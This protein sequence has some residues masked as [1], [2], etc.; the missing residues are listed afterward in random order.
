MYDALSAFD[1]KDLEH[2]LTSINQQLTQLPQTHAALWDLFKTL[3]NKKDEEAY[4]RLLADEAIV[5]KTHGVDNGWV[6]PA[7]GDNLT[8]CACIS[9]PRRR[10]RCL[11]RCY[12]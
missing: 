12:G 5:E 4:E 9:W 7:L 8:P 2:V 11:R 10:G 6:R 1:E 3:A